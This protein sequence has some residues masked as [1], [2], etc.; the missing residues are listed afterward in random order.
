MLSRTDM[1]AR[2]IEIVEMY[3][4]GKYSMEAIGDKYNVSRERIRQI[5]KLGGV[6]GADLIERRRAE[7][8]AKRISDKADRKA[9]AIIAA[10]ENDWRCPVCGGLN[11]RRGLNRSTAVTCSSECSGLYPMLRPRI[12]REHWSKT[13]AEALVRRQKREGDLQPFQVNHAQS[14]IDGTNNIHP[15]RFYYNETSKAGQAYERMLELRKEL[16]TE[17]DRTWG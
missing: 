4:T 2:D 8:L 13:Q 5:L 6:L 14:M 1:Q 15:E 9:R 12:D 3:L 10:K 16:G 7:K 11:V 17:E